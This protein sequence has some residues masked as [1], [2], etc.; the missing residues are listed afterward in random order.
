MTIRTLGH[1]GTAVNSQMIRRPHT[2]RLVI[3]IGRRELPIPRKE[4]EKISTNT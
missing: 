1:I 4:P 2:P 3:I